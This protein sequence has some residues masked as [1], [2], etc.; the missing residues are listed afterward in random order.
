MLQNFI[1]HNELETELQFLINNSH[2]LD[3][4]LCFYGR[5]NQVS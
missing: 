4:V 2:K 3:G 5:P 1:F